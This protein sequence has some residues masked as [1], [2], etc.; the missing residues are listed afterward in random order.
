M[1]D[2]RALL[3]FP[4]PFTLWRTTCTLSLY[5]LG[6]SVGEARGCGG[7]GR[8]QSS[9][10]SRFLGNSGALSALK[11]IVH[12]LSSL[13]RLFHSVIYNS[14]I[15]TIQKVMRISCSCFYNKL[16]V[17]F[18]SDRR[19]FFLKKFAGRKNSQLCKN[20]QKICLFWDLILKLSLA[21][22][23]K[24][25]LTLW[26]E[27]FSVL[28]SPSCARTPWPVAGAALMWLARRTGRGTTPPWTRKGGRGHRT[29]A[30][31]I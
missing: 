7:G 17:I 1:G 6:R 28:C 22:R 13:E 26:R 12:I 4:S 5:L 8:E 14:V 20:P 10:I 23:R 9:S 21:T 30:I 2:W 15:T 19:N 27:L 11:Q 16:G 25:S 24:L 3:P 18:V 29:Q 31:V